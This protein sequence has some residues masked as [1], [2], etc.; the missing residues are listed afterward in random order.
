MQAGYAYK[1]R[2]CTFLVTDGLLPISNAE[3]VIQKQ[4]ETSQTFFTDALG[5]FKF[6]GNGNFDYAVNVSGY[7]IQTGSFTLSENSIFEQVILTKMY[8]M[9]FTNKDED[10]P[11]PQAEIM[12][13]GN[14]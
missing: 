11:L 14:T 8:E 5:E 6:I 12:Y 9:E 7:K 3:I 10:N 13:E 2:T 1:D 4:G